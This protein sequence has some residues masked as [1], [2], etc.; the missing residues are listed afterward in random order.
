MP[1]GLATPSGTSADVPPEDDLDAPP[2]ALGDCA[3]AD[4]TSLSD[5]EPLVFPTR[6]WTGTGTGPEGGGGR[7]EG[8]KREGSRAEA[9]GEPSRPPPSASPPC[10]AQGLG[11]SETTSSAFTDERLLTSISRDLPF[12]T[13]VVTEQRGI[14]AQTQENLCPKMTSGLI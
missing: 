9:G 12:I 4:S 7:G 2:W 3:S 1:G 8:Q 6:L 10:R 13:E 14:T 5:V 11:V